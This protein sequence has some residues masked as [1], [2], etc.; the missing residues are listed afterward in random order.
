MLSKTIPL[1]LGERIG[2]ILQGAIEIRHHNKKPSIDN[3][4]PRTQRQSLLKPFTIHKA[5]EGDILGFDKISKNPLTWLISMQDETE[6]LLL[7]KK[8][9]Y[10][11][12]NLQKQDPERQI[13]L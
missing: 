10:S 13:I 5:I 12:F 6:V 11:L 1:F 4:D 7:N 9:F 2:I 3:P 8:E